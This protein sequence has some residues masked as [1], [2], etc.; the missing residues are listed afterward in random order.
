MTDLP[1][2][3][4]PW[5]EAPGEEDR[6]F[7]FA[8]SGAAYVALAVQAARSVRGT[9]P[10]I[11]ID[12][13]TS[14]LV[15]EGVFDRVH[16]LETDW[17]RPK[18]EALARSRFA[19][20]LYLDADL[21]VLA[22]MSDVFWLL[23]RFDIAAAQVQHANQDFAR[24][25]WRQAMPHAFPQV[26]SGVLGLRASDATRAFMRQ[27][28]DALHASGLNQDQPIL[29]E[30]LWSTDLRLAILP[31]E[32]NLRADERVWKSSW[33]DPAP[34]VLHSSRFHKAM[35]GADAPSPEAV[36]GRNFMRMA[37]NLIGGDRQ[38]TA[39]ADRPSGRIARFFGRL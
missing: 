28:H 18:F 15:P 9:H 21:V 3:P 6:G 19:R 24:R 25:V 31:P 34:R 37:R 2:P 26:N 29:R 14:D 27:V 30:M 4:P 12:I 16:P 13:Y 1:A 7:V 11:P 22:D 20:T 38:L 33:R 10:G 35:T 17:F 8:V 5:P 39:E 36:F 23:N 32:Y